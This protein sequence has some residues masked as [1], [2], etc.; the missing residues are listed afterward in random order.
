MPSGITHPNGNT[1]RLVSFFSLAERLKFV[2]MFDVRST[3]S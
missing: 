3:S 2:W 1:G